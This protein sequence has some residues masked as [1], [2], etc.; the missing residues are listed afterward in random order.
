M[1]HVLLLGGAGFVGSHLCEKLARAGFTVT[2]LTRRR[3]HARAVQHLPGLSVVEGNVHDDATLARVVAG[4]DAVV[5]LVAILH[6]TQTAFEQ[7]HVGLPRRVLQ[8]CAAHGVRQLVHVSALGVG[9]GPP[10]ELPSMYLRSKAQGEQLLRAALPEGMALS[11]LRPSVV[12]GAGDQFLTLFA[13]LQRLAPCMPLAGAQARFQPVWVEDVATAIVRCLQGHAVAL[14]RVRTL[15]CCG[16]EV[17]TLR[18]L[19]EFSAEAAGL[20]PVPVLPLPDWAGQLQARLM[21]CLPG[22]PLMSRDNLASMRVP[23]V[24]T[25]GMPGLELLGIRAMSPR[26][27]AP[28]YLRRH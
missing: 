21:E 9:D 10:H 11:L 18:Q 13:R 12:F 6:G 1:N 19:V 27:V 24:A 26:S 22:G 3:A 14:G 5:N 8:A 16:P 23:N 2:V 4:H 28:A 17:M 15:E 7:V 25:P 20:Q